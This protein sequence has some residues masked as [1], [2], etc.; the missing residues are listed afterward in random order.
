VDTTEYLYD[1]VWQTINMKAEDLDRAATTLANH[2][3]SEG[4][5][6]ISVTRSTQPSTI[7]IMFARTPA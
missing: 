3:A 7:G 6:V 5:T 2:R 4:W 1:S